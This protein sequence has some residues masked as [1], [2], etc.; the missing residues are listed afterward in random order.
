MMNTRCRARDCC[1]LLRPFGRRKQRKWCSTSCDNRQRGYDTYHNDPEHRA[2]HIALVRVTEERN[3]QSPEWRAQ[4][5]AW[6][7]EYSRTRRQNDPVIRERVN[8]VNNA[9][10]D[11]VEE[12]DLTEDQWL[13]K[14]SYYG[15][16][17]AYCSAPHEHMDHAMPRALGGLHTISNVVPSCASCNLRKGA[18]HPD[19]FD[20]IVFPGTGHMAHANLAMLPHNED[21]PTKG[22]THA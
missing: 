2:R 19:D 15:W 11:W 3:K 12:G 1:N 7:T 20:P 10:R 8:L 4:R 21:T 6:D 13:A 18:K 9:R 17:C 22:T 16:T 14:L 5:K